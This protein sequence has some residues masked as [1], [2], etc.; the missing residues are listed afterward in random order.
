MCGMLIQLPNEVWMDILDWLR[1]YRFILAFSQIGDRQFNEIV[2]HWLHKW[3]KNVCIDLDIKS[4]FFPY[5]KP[6]T[7]MRSRACLFNLTERMWGHGHW[8]P[9]GFPFAEGPMPE[10][11]DF[12]QINIEFLDAKVLTFLRQMQSKFTNIHLHI[13]YKEESES[14]TES[15]IG[16]L[17]PLLHGIQSVQINYDGRSEERRVGK[18][19]RN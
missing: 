10:N 6:E 14:R 19:C 4:L 5:Y 17:M 2:Q 13:S 9:L 1:G 3:T 8:S 11:M 16:H 15:A 18:E 12:R 7:P